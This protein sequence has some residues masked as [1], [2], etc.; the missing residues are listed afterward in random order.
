MVATW[1]AFSRSRGLGI[2]RVAD[3]GTRLSVFALPLPCGENRLIPKD[4]WP[5]LVMSPKACRAGG[6]PVP[7]ITVMATT[8]YSYVGAG[9]IRR[10]RIQLEVGFTAGT[11]Y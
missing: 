2:L 9:S 8:S 6:V 11:G 3:L 7:C 5:E 10:R 4:C 1:V